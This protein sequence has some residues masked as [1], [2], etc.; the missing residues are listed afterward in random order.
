M[1]W[2]SPNDVAPHLLSELVLVRLRRP[3]LSVQELL[4]RVLNSRM[5]ILERWL[6]VDIRLAFFAEHVEVSLRLHLED[7]FVEELGIVD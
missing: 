2:I 3:H 6:R 7:D 1:N 5:K 4:H